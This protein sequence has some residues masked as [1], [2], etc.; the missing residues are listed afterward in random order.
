VTCRELVDFLSAYLD[1]DLRADER[2]RFENHLSICPACVTY[3]DSYRE[4]V[5]LGKVVC[6]ND[7]DDVPDD[8]PEALIQAILAA[9]QTAN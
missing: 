2:D 4:T 5:K 1:D 9:R 3:L 6:A 7:T 8:V